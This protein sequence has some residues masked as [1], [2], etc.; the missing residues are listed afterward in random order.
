MKVFSSVLDGT[1]AIGVNRLTSRQVFVRS[2][3]AEVYS[4]EQMLRLAVLL[5]V[6]ML[7]AAV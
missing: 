2:S 7:A 5:G 1:G 3:M 6:T 4:C